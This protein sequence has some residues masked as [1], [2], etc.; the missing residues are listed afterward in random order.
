[1][2][3]GIK[4]T[5]KDFVN[6]IKELVEEEYIV[7]SEY[8]TSKDKVLFKHNIKK[9]GKTFEMRASHFINTGCRCPYCDLKYRK[10]GRRVKKISQE[11]IDKIIE[12]YTAQKKSTREIMEILDIDRRII[13]KI[14]KENNIELNG[15]TKLH[16]LKDD[17]I[18]IQIYKEKNNNNTYKQLAEKYNVSTQ[19]IYN[20]RYV[21]NQIEYDKYAKHKLD[22]NYFRIIDS[23]EKAYILGFLMADGCVYKT[24]KKCKEPNRLCI[25]ISLKDRSVLEFIKKQLK[26]DAKIKDYT[27]KNTYSNNSM[28]KINFDSTQLCKDLSKYGIIPNKTGKESFPTIPKMY[29]RHFIRGFF[30]GDGTSFSNGR[31]GF[32]SNEKMLLQIKEILEQEIDIQYKISIF[33]EKRKQNVYYLIINSKED[34]YKL[35][36]YLYKNATFYLQRKYDNF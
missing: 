34:C 11:N 36:K 3:R 23:Q 4:R 20:H 35:K 30:D 27:P 25:N 22:V 1:M 7:L 21:L 12:L 6:K 32:T 19:S 10:P 13:S 29:R 9:C 8:K 24:D 31:I 5:H 33:K 18:Y 28:S 14:L 17:D 15:N 16:S 26:S 2:S